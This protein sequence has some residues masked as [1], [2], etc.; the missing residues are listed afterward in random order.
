MAERVR[1]IVRQ[2]DR[3]IKSQAEIETY[4]VTKTYTEGPR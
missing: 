3:Q 1:G 2:R 4:S